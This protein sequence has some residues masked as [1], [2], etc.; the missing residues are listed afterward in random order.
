SCYS[1]MQV[2]SDGTLAILYEDESYSA[3]N[4]YAINYVTITTDQVEAWIEELDQAEYDFDA[5]FDKTFIIKKY[6]TSAG[7]EYILSPKYNDAGDVKVYRT[8]DIN[9]SAEMVIL[10]DN[11]NEGFYYVYDVKSNY[12]LKGSANTDEGTEWTFSTTPVTVKLTDN[13]S[14]HSNWTRTDG[15]I[16]LIQ[17]SQ[18][19]MANAYGGAYGNQV[20]NYSIEDDPGSNWYIY[21]T[22]NSSTSSVYVDPTALY[23]LKNVNNSNYITSGTDGTNLGYGE[24]ASAGTYALIPVSDNNGKFYIYDTKNHNFLTPEETTSNG[25]Q[26]TVSSTTPSMITVTNQ[27]QRSKNYSWN[28]N[29]IMY[30]L[31]TYYANAYGGSGLVKNYYYID[32]GSHW[33]LERVDNSTPAIVE[34]NGITNNV[35][36]LVESGVTAGT[37]LQYTAKLNALGEAS[38]ATQYVPFDLTLPENTSAYY[39]NEVT[40][41]TANLEELSSGIP[42]LTP[43]VIKNSNGANSVSFPVTKDLSS[44]DETNLLKGT[45]VPIDLDLSNEST[46]YSLGQLNGNIGFYKFKAADGTTS[47]TLGAN[48]AYLQIPVPTSNSVRGFKFAFAADDSLV[49]ED[50][51]FVDGINEVK[52]TNDETYYNLNGLRVNTLRKGIYIVNGKK[53]VV[54]DNQR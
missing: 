47:I 45:L 30:S 4:G 50:G 11:Q 25:G 33:Y 40:G 29:G 20:K 6:S 54:V 24:K 34:M 44:F 32:K 1:T 35:E 2:L 18:N 37:T 12:Y 7:F 15:H 17:N 46:N 22:E 39:I 13:T 52:T 9:E 10:K 19:S 53:V 27:I 8:A 41:N 36:S 31:G 14:N 42:A 38:W 51:G 48:K 23:Y 21:A 28:P 5:N 49:S 3:G 16:F 43:V 26:W